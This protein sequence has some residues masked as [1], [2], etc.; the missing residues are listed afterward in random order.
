MHDSMNQR[1]AFQQYQ[2]LLALNN[3]GFEKTDTET[4]LVTICSN[5]M[6]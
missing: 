4:A 6:F 3:D 1:S 2:G 5:H